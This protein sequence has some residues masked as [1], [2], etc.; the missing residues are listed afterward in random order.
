MVP[1]TLGNLPLFRPQKFT[2]RVLT[3]T[4]WVVGKRR[5]GS[6]FEKSCRDLPRVKVAEHCGY[7]LRRPP[8]PSGRGRNPRPEGQ[9]LRCRFSVRRLSW[10]QLPHVNV[11]APPPVLWPAVPG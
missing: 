5:R 4:N 7:R 1:D 11:S 8:C 10:N 6:G 2:E 3:P 9:G